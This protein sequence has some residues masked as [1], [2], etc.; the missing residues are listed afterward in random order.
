MSIHNPTY[1]AREK[2]IAASSKPISPKVKTIG[3]GLLAVG[4]LVFIAGLFVAPERAWR[5]WHVNWIWFSVI[6]SAAVMWAGISR[7]VTA[8]WNRS[9][10]RFQEGYGAFLPVSFIMLLLSMTVGAKYIFPYIA[11]PNGLPNVEKVIYYERTFW[12]LRNLGLVGLLFFL[13]LWFLYNSVRLD[14]GIMSQ[15]T[16]AK[17]AQGLLARMRAGFGD[18]RRELHTQ[19]SLQGKIATAMAIVFGIGWMMVLYDLSMGLDVYFFSTLYGWWGFMAGLLSA[20]T[21]LFLLLLIWKKHFAN[22]V[23]DE[24]ITP[25]QQHDLGKITFAWT[26]FWGYSTFAQLLIIWYGNIGEETHWFRLRLIDPWMHLTVSVAF[27]IFFAPFPGL[28]SKAAKMY[29]PTFVLFA[30]VSLLG[31]WLM[32]YMEVY[33]SLYGIPESVPFGLWEIGSFALFMGLWITC[34]TQFFEAFPRLRIFMMSSKYRDE[35]QIP[36]DARTMEPLPAHE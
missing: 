28:V 4:A 20:T 19:H 36:V 30:C 33:P 32:R 11:D 10:I 15:W 5:S 17:W 3:L 1:P 16:G 9:I 6:S 14:V 25:S 31:T 8:R 23:I 22:D 26:G 18:E 29:T 34:Y 7:I 27:L 2:L 24:I 12:T 21:S 35:V 13:Q